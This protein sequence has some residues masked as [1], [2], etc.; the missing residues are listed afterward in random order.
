MSKSY[1][2]KESKKMTHFQLNDGTWAY[3]MGYGRQSGSL[4]HSAMPW[5]EFV[6]WPNDCRLW[7][8]EEL[9]QD[10]PMWMTHTQ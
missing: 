1:N 8:E 7:I 3:A 2:L 5:S 10:P 4:H 9:S 6:N